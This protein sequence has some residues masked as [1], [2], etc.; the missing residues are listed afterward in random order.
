MPIPSSAATRSA[1]LTAE[2]RRGWQH[3]TLTVDRPGP[4]A[5]CSRMYFGTWVVFPDPV[6]PLTSTQLRFFSVASR[7]PFSSATGRSSHT[8]A[9]SCTAGCAMRRSHASRSRSSAGVRS[10]AFGSASQSSSSSLG[11]SSRS[12]VSAA[13]TGTAATSSCGKRGAVLCSSLSRLDVATEKAVRRLSVMSWSCFTTL[14]ASAAHDSHSSRYSGASDLYS[15]MFFG[16]SSWY[17]ATVAASSRASASDFR[18]S[19]AWNSWRAGM[20]AAAAPPDLVDFSSGVSTMAMRTSDGASPSCLRCRS[21]RMRIR[22]FV[23][24][25]FRFSTGD[26]PVHRIDCSLSRATLSRGPSSLR[27]SSSSSFFFCNATFSGLGPL[28]FPF[29]FFFFFASSSPPAASPSS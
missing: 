25:S 16:C 18:V 5:A 1:T 22:C 3:T 26:L 13:D 23:A 2:M 29:F 19:V 9:I 20:P 27:R 14:S 4:N 10:K 7:L 15:G 17:S 8:A 21:Y 11:M 24:C 28:T 6:S 12:S